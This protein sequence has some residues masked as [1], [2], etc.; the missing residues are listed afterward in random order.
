MSENE[1]ER[2]GQNEQEQEQEQETSEDQETQTAGMATE[3]TAEPDDVDAGDI[4]ENEEIAG[5]LAIR[6]TVRSTAS[7]LV[8]HEF[9]AVSE[10]SPIEEGW[11]AVVEVVERS[12][13]PDTQDVIGRYE[14]ELEEEGRIQ[15]YRGL[16]RYRRGDTTMFE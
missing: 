3:E 9:D 12:S 2:T 11:R 15:G 8:G 1:T 13:V 7:Q 14:I 4:D 16:D 5:V 10:I 6:N